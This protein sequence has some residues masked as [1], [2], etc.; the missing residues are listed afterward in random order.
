MAFTEWKFVRGKIK[1]HEGFSLVELLIVIAIISILVAVGIP[2]YKEYKSKARKSAV[3]ATL[4]SLN[5][6]AFVL[7]STEQQITPKALVKAVKGVDVSELKVG[8]K[9]GSDIWCIEYKRTGSSK[10]HCINE[11]GEID[12][13]KSTCDQS[14]YQCKP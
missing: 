10:S 7:D 6:A 8:W 3:E 4:S 1:P 5:K 12:E 14:K 9:T 2:A 11:E 13:T